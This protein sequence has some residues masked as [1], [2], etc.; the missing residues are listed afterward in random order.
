M[1]PDADNNQT[2]GRK[3]DS[4]IN[5]RATAPNTWRINSYC[6]AYAVTVLTVEGPVHGSYMGGVPHVDTRLIEVTYIV[7]KIVEVTDLADIPGFN[8]VPKKKRST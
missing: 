6:Q 8:R 2:T 5:A 1:A 3:S 7:G 4:R